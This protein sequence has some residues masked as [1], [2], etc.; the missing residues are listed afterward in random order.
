MKVR[1]WFASKD[2]A[3]AALA[4]LARHVDLTRFED[5]WT[6]VEGMSI[7]FKSA[8]APARE[9]PCIVLVHGLGLSCRY[10]LPTAQ[11]LLGDYHLLVPDLPGFGDSAKPDRVLTID[12]LADCLAAWIKKLELRP[13]L[14]GNSLACQIIAA[15][16]DRHPA[17]AAA[18]I[19]QGPTTPPNE[20][21]IFWQFIRWRQNLG[22]D[23]PDM[24]VISRDDY[25]KSGRRRVGMTF[26]HG[27]RD[28]MEKRLSRIGQPVLVVRG[29]LDPICRREWARDIAERL[30]RG[31]FVEIP[32]V[33]HT[34]VFTAPAQLAEVSRKFLDGGALPAKLI[35]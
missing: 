17:I 27:L 18:A 2:T 22:Y 11:A 28:A 12:E 33:A 20:R 21:S 13:V 16:M 8:R 6:D 24:K 32:G 31:S 25:L 4:A 14:L 23:P 7:Y 30:P 9:A 10:M 26:L 19:L 3:A 35:P 29:E 15:A 34:M 5:A 1:R